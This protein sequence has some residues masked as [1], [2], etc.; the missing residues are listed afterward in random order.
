MRLA[1][2]IES[3]MERILADWERFAATRLPAA[4]RM[5]PFELR[6]HARQILQAIVIDLSVP[7]T[8]DE[9]TAKSKG[10]APAPYAETAAQVH[11][12]LRARSGFDI[13]QLASEYRALRASVLRLWTDAVTPQA[14]HFDDMLRF[15]EAIDQAL[16]ESIV[17][18]ATQVEQ[19][20][21]LL[22]GMLGHDMRNPL[23]AI[24]MTAVHLSR[25][26][27]GDEITRAAGRLINSGSQMQALL[28][29]LLDFSRTQL[30]VGISVLPQEV[31]LRDVVND[32]IEVVRAARPTRDIDF[33]STGSCTGWWDGHRL[34]QALSNLLINAIDYGRA[35]SSV[36]VGL[37]CDE[38]VKLAVCNKG[39]TIAPD[40]LRGLFEPLRRGKQHRDGRDTGLGLGLFIAR[41]TA[42]AHGG[43]IEARSE[44]DETVF[45]L[46]LPRRKAPEPAAAA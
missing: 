29:D 22:L 38:S 25:M 21:N 39:A 26:N 33:E 13:N 35:D 34:Q 24:Q 37:V 20:R 45:T 6:D 5:E 27:A 42:R 10:L 23:Q 9:Q 15:N 7:Q 46:N 14:G 19:S 28:D 11:A 31:D 36:R 2:F 41:E 3:E 4:Q 18:F 8:R 12:V 30:G 17:H 1:Q 44:G 43:D 32:A 40:M 16:A